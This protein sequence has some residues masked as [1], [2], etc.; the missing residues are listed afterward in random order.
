MTEVRF[1]SVFRPLYAKEKHARGDR[2]GLSSPD[3][4]G[5][6]SV[7]G[8][9]G[10]SGAAASRWHFA[11]D[12]ALLSPAAPSH[13]HSPQN[14]PIPKPWRPFLFPPSP[15][16]SSPD[17]V[18][19]GEAWNSPDRPWIRS[20]QR[21]GATCSP[22]VLPPLSGSRGVDLGDTGDVKN[23]TGAGLH[24]RFPCSSSKPRCREGKRHTSNIWA[25]SAGIARAE[26]F[27]LSS[28]LWFAERDWG[29][30]FYIPASDKPAH[31]CVTHMLTDVSRL[32]RFCPQ[33]ALFFLFFPFLPLPDI[34]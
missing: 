27:L 26:E 21:R 19:G 32:K 34:T 3:G 33:R 28:T 8:G 23:S 18:P 25:G 10:D 14:S 30:R 4:A 6:R 12:G 13:P 11:G 29:H 15:S 20:H 9:T 2:E 17:A 24:P 5:K 22:P 7:C 16:G 1:S 31:E